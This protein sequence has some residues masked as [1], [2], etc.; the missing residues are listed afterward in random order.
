MRVLGIDPGYA[1]K[2]GLGWSVVD[3]GGIRPILIAHGVVQTAAQWP[4]ATRVAYLG[5][6][7]RGV[8][9]LHQVQSL[10]VEDVGGAVHGAQKSRGAT[11]TDRRLSA[12]GDGW[13]LLAG[14][15]GLPYSL[16]LPAEW[17]KAV[18]GTTRCEK[19]DVRDA[20]VRLVGMPPK[21]ALHSSDA[22]AIAIAGGARLSLEAKM[23]KWAEDG[24]R[25]VQLPVER[26]QRARSA[27]ASSR[28][29]RK[30]QLTLASLSE[31][32]SA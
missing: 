12:V 13:L 18:T 27:A 1:A 7:L 26:A 9:D 24:Q 2:T 6:Q 29:T 22:A 3:V 8:I 21:A 4:W 31:R 14:A 20:L 10:A 23:G 16:V 5:K 15:L 30:Q 28:R 32:R 17:R 25:V 11:T 19:E